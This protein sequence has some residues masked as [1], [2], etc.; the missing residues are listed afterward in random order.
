MALTHLKP[1]SYPSWKEYYWTYQSKLAE[2]HYIPL[3]ASWG[4]SLEGKKVLD[5]GC[6]DGGFTAAL[7]DAGAICTGV[8]VRDFGWEHT[9][10]NLRFLQQD[11]LADEAQLVLGDDYDIIILRDVIEHISLRSKHQFMAA[12]RKFTSSQG[13]ILMTFPPFYSPFGLHQQTFLKSFLKKLPYLGW[14]PGPILDVLLKIVGESDKART[15]VKEI[16]E[17]RMTL[18]RF[19]KMTKKLN[20]P[21]ENEKYYL[22]RPSHE[23]RYG[24][25]LRESRLAT[26][27]ILREIFIL[28]SVFKL[29]MPQD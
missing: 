7:A 2:L 13:I 27:P 11:I 17:C 22:I 19:R 10:A 8:E 14:I 25:K 29:S 9:H 5:V 20:Y 16:R 15:D 23:L 1:E 24:W 12:L 28:G 3:F 6:G 26:V 18:R 4:I 21:I